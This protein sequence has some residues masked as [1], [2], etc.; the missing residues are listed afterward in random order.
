MTINENSISDEL[1]ALTN[2]KEDAHYQLNAIIGKLT[3]HTIGLESRLAGLEGIAET[4]ASL[5]RSQQAEIEQL[6]TRLD[7]YRAKQAVPMPLANLAEAAWCESRQA[8]ADRIRN[9]V[10]TRKQVEAQ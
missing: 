1:V 5:A 4:L 6:T 9:T 8:R 3:K 10:K 2:Q 7:T